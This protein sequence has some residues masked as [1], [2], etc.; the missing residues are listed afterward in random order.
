MNVSVATQ[1]ILKSDWERY[2]SPVAISLS[3]MGELVAPISN[4]LI[5]D[6]TLLSGGCANTNYKINFKSH[7]PVVVR[8]YTRE[9]QALIRERDIHHLVHGQIPAA[10][11]LFA[12]ESRTRIDFPYAIFSYV[13]GI[14]LRDLIYSNHTEAIVSCY[15][16]AGVHIATLSRITFP[17]GGFFERG[18]RVRPFLRDEAYLNLA[19]SLVR[20]SSVK[21]GLGIELIRRVRALLEAAEQFLPKNSCA[22]LTHADFDPSNILVTNL[23]GSWRVSA[24]LDWEFSF[25]G[26]Y[27]LDIGQMVRYSHKLPSCYEMALVEGIRAGGLNL[28]PSWKRCAK[29]MDLLCLL[30]LVHANPK[31]KRPML[32]NDVVELIFHTVEN[33][34]NF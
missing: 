14:S 33:W 9:P 17:E 24:I 16:D 28:I 6:A 27:F 13:N 21:R 29:L 1:K 31:S 15:F 22:H 25:A 7:P 34:K 23:N 5:I 18:L 19:F 3:Q 10:Q 4:D 30:Q 11:M 8:I 2:R 20:S 32:H 12:D 26:I